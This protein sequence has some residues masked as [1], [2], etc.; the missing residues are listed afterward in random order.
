[1]ET[2]HRSGNEKNLATPFGRFIELIL[3]ALVPR[4]QRE[5]VIG[6]FRQDVTTVAEA[7]QKA[8]DTVPLIIS[9]E[10]E[11]TFKWRLVFAQGCVLYIAVAGSPLPVP[12]VSTL[13]TIAAALTALVL[14]DAYTNPD[15]ASP[16][17]AIVDAAV[18]ATF[19]II[20]QLL[21]V[22]IAPSLA[23]AAGVVARGT[24]IGLLLM[25]VL[26]SIFW[27][28]RDNTRLTSPYVWTWKMSALWFAGCAADFLTRTS[29]V[30][31]D[32]IPIVFIPLLSVWAVSAMRN[33]GAVAD[34][35]EF[36]PLLGSHHVSITHRLT[37]GEIL[38]VY[39]LL[40]PLSF[41]ISKS[42]DVIT[43]SDP[44]WLWGWANLIAA[45]GALSFCAYTLR[46]AP[47]MNR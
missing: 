33:R 21:L 3:P 24:V 1:V 39:L 18:T 8:K 13:L 40:L 38:F 28:A 17:E 14:R 34:G 2:Q 26:R 6:D 19:I 16:R 7:F 5:Q 15:D 45:V 36:A 30:K 12:F 35:K 29:A 31:K 47:E 22:L 37:S 32:D 4:R 44:Q 9:R 41:A 46:Y 23:P 11:R 10:V 20:A 25:S 42:L 27:K 43:T